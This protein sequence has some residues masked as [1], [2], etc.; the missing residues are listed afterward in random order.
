MPA[1]R[2]VEAAGAVGGRAAPDA[3]VRAGSMPMLARGRMEAARAVGRRTAPL[4]VLL[5]VPMLMLAR[6]RVNAPAPIA[7]RS[8]MSTFSCHVNLHL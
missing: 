7:R 3:L 6:G 4:A 1:G 5:V 8:A 2:A